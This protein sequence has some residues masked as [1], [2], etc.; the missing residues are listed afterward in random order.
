MLVDVEGPT[1]RHP[2]GKIAILDHCGSPEAC[3]D[4]QSAT[5]EDIRLDVAVVIENVSSRK[6]L[7]ARSHNDGL[8]K[9]H[10]GRLAYHA[11]SLRHDFD[12]II[13]FPKSIDGLVSS[14]KRGCQS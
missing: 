13:R 7:R 10:F 8:R 3:A 11:Q 14:V 2:Q 6:R 4:T 12:D 5:Q 9:R 1:R